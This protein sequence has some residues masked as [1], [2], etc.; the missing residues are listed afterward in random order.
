M[1][2]CTHS[3]VCVCV[4]VVVC[5]RAVVCVC[6]RGREWVGRASLVVTALALNA[7]GSGFKPHSR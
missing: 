1:C 6:E 2:V 4:H 3:S 7:R 5:V